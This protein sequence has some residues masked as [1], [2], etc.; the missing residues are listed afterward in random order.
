M[1]VPECGLPPRR[2]PTRLRR[3]APC[4]PWPVRALRARPPLCDLEALHSL[5]VSPVTL[6]PLKVTVA[7]FKQSARFGSVG[8]SPAGRHTPVLRPLQPSSPCCRRPPRPGPRPPSP[9]CR[10]CSPR[11]LAPRSPALRP[12]RHSSREPVFPGTGV[13]AGV[14]TL[15]PPFRA[16]A[17]APPA[18]ARTHSFLAWTRLPLGFTRLRFVPASHGAAFPLPRPARLLRAAPCRLRARDSWIPPSFW[19]NHMLQAHVV[20]PALPRISCF[21]RSRLPRRVGGP[22][23]CSGHCGSS[24]VS[25]SWAFQQAE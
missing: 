6:A 8:D 15:A 4:Q 9:G 16:G 11:L 18:P 24:S 2:R 5:S 1:P 23:G 20:L 17:R 14:P 25:A 22:A 21:S 3:P 13:E 10:A 12:R 19:P 7:L